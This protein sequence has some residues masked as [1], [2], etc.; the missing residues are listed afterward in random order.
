MWLEK[1]G[2]VKKEARRE[3]PVNE[4][5]IADGRK[6]EHQR[7][8]GKR[9]ESLLFL[10]MCVVFTS[11][12]LKLGWVRFGAMWLLLLVRWQLW[13]ELSLCT[14]V[15]ASVDVIWIPLN[16]LSLLINNCHLKPLFSYVLQFLVYAL[17]Q[18]QEPISIQPCSLYVTDLKDRLSF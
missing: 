1:P 2:A 9:K 11:P 17:W 4:N 14:W 12:S 3:S 6:R 15:T 5:K 16:S 7:F 18:D 10:L 13:L 8:W